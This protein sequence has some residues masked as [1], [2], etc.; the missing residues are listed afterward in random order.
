MDFF[1]HRDFS[2]VP[3]FWLAVLHAK[4]PHSLPACIVG[5]SVFG[6]SDLRPLH[7]AGLS[8]YTS[9]DPRYSIDKKFGYV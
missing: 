3:P 7:E 9:E 4:G 1:S 5:D 6:L 2:L 8:E